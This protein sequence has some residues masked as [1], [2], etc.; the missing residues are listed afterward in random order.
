[1]VYRFL[2][3][4]PAVAGLLP[5]LLSGCAF[6]AHA[7]PNHR[8]LR[9]IPLIGLPVDHHM[10][11]YW[12]AV[13]D[14]K[15]VTV[16]EPDRQYAKQA[17][18]AKVASLAPPVLAPPSAQLNLSTLSAAASTAAALSAS[19]VGAVHPPLNPVASSTPV[20]LTPAPLPNQPAPRRTFTQIKANTAATPPPVS[21][22][23]QK[24]S[25]P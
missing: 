1:V 7:V 16:I 24:T 25:G 23:R 12:D 9:A 13:S 2:G 18:W 10:A 3:L 15:R 8:Y 6:G 22:K 20:F 19:R 5:R 21:N 11:A 4:R 17:L 14:A